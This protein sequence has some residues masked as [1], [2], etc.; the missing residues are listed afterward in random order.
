[1]WDTGE[2][3]WLIEKKKKIY[4]RSIA[5]ELSGIW[6]TFNFS[7][8]FG[9]G[10]YQMDEIV[11]RRKEL[12]QYT[13][14]EWGWQRKNANAIHLPESPVRAQERKRTEHGPSGDGSQGGQERTLETDGRVTLGNVPLFQGQLSL[15]LGYWG[16]KEVKNGSLNFSGNWMLMEGLGVDLMR[17]GEILRKVRDN[18]SSMV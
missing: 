11:K 15:N 6:Q 4:A 2:S 5:Q 3:I 9:S 17:L 7:L 14:K 16:A 10:Q 1:M 12:G 18:E 13:K 8:W